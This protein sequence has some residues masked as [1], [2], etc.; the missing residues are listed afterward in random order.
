MIWLLRFLRTVCVIVVLLYVLHFVG[1]PMIWIIKAANP[2]LA[3][4]IAHV[5]LA[6]F[7]ASF[8]SMFEIEHRT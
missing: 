4:F 2:E 8:V 7:F 3:L 6:C 5:V 1:L